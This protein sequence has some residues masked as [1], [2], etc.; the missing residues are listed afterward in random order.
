MAELR[1]KQMYRVMKGREERERIRRAH[2]VRAARGDVGRY[3][4]LTFHASNPILV[5]ALQVLTENIGDAEVR[6]QA[7]SVGVEKFSRT[8][9]TLGSLHALSLGICPPPPAPALNQAC[10]PCA[11]FQ[12]IVPSRWCSLG[13]S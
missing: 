11:P 6:L 2:K 13:L 1:I 10:Q 9:R 12:A 5:N 4:C 7:Y 8:L 3:H